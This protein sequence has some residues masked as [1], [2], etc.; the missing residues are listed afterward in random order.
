[1]HHE[2]GE[3]H[4]RGRASHC[5]QAVGGCRRG[6]AP[7][8]Q[9]PHPGLG[10]RVSFVN[11][12]GHQASTPAPERLLEMITEAVKLV[13]RGETK[14]KGPAAIKPFSAS[15]DRPALLAMKPEIVAPP[16]SR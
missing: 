2:P 10:S 4:G 6:R 15:P 8:D 9:P 1:M 13:G 16:N 3:Q 7:L 14:R 12:G 5:R 11:G